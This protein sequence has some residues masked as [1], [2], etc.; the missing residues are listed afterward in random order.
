MRTIPALLLV[1]AA[2]VTTPDL[3]GAEAALEGARQAL[4]FARGRLVDKEAALGRVRGQIGSLEEFLAPKREL[5]Q[6]L[7]PSGPESQEDRLCR[8]IGDSRELSLQPR[9]RVFFE[10]KCL[11][12][13]GACALK[14]SPRMGAIVRDLVARTQEDISRLRSE[15]NALKAEIAQLESDI[16]RLDGAYQQATKAREK[17][18]E[19]F[20]EMAKRI[21]GAAA[22]AERS[23]AATFI[24]CVDNALSPAALQY[25]AGAQR[26]IVN[27]ECRREEAAYLRAC[28]AAAEAG[29]DIAGICAEQVN[30]MIRGVRQ[31]K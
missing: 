1:T 16:P 29:T 21:L 30:A 5:A 4:G 11:C 12:V 7:P 27:I 22:V 19:P 24:A 23:P 6:K 2:S 13:S 31:T 26:N 25:D 8:A 9:D 14:D 20:V 10:D 3:P 18:Y 17:A 15:E 28:Y